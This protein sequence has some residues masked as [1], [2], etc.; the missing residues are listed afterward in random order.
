LGLGEGRI[1][2]RGWLALLMAAR[3]VVE[4]AGGRRKMDTVG[5]RR[6]R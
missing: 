4:V 1:A 5:G 2:L 3:M 6:K